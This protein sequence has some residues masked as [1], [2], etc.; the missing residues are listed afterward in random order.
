M[1]NARSRH[2]CGI[3]AAALLVV[4]AVACGSDKSTPATAKSAPPSAA[5]IVISGMQFGDQLTVSP[6]A[7]VAVSNKD[8][9]EHTVTSDTAGKFDSEVEG[10][11][12]STFTAPTTPGSYPFHCT[13]HPSMHGVLVVR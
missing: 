7:Q 13:Y 8:S 9:A 11:A 5:Q 10:G 3:A 2:I 1:S 12:Q 4:T 6:G